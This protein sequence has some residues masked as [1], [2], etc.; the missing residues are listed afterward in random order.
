MWSW[1][2]EHL[3]PHSFALIVFVYLVIGCAALVKLFAAKESGLK[4]RCVSIIALCLFSGAQFVLP[5]IGNGCADT[6][7]QLYM[8][9]IVTYFLLFAFI[10]KIVLRA[11]EKFGWR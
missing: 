9:N 1:V 5:A 7:K 6:A 8:F 11:S 10:V 3:A 4:I 2:T